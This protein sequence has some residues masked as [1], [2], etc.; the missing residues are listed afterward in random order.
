[1]KLLGIYFLIF[2]YS[3]GVVSFGRLVL[4]SG[5]FLED[6]A[7]ELRLGA[8]FFTG[9]SIFL[10]LWKTLTLFEFRALVALQLLSLVIFTLLFKDIFRKN[11][12][13]KFLSFSISI[14]VVLIFTNLETLRSLTPLTDTFFGDSGLIDPFASFGSVVHTFRAS[15]ISLFTIQ[16]DDIPTLGQHIGQSLLAA[17]PTFLGVKSLLANLNIWLISI[18]VFSFIF[19]LGLFKSLSFGKYQALLLSFLAFSAQSAFSL[20]AISTG[21]TG[22]S[23]L[24]MSSSDCLIGVFS[25]FTLFLMY[26]ELGKNKLMFFLIQGLFILSWSLTA[27]HL[28]LI[29]FGVLLLDFLLK[30][31]KFE[32]Y[33]TQYEWGAIFSFLLFAVVSAGYGGMLAPKGLHSNVKI[34]GLMQVSRSDRKAISFRNPG[35]SF[36]SSSTITRWKQSLSSDEMIST[37]DAKCTGDTRI[38]NFLTLDCRGLS[39]PAGVTFQSGTKEKIA[40]ALK[41]IPMNTYLSLRVIFWPLISLILFFFLRKKID[42]G[43]YKIGPTFIALFIGGSVITGTIALYGYVWELSRFFYTGWILGV[44]FLLLQTKFLK[45]QLRAVLITTFFIFSSL[46]PI[47]EWSL[48]IKNVFS[49]KPSSWTT[50][51]LQDKGSVLGIKKRYEYMLMKHDLYGSELQ[52][53]R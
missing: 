24:N 37:Y 36:Y 44:V 1:M 43:I 51:T 46:G 25:F 5:K 21:D 14:I 52:T 6:K 7:F 4:K 30:K 12:K 28:I 3:C 38:L 15:N 34:P 9:L 10:M 48:D 41:V 53:I 8:S 26:L 23:I 19:L 22:G 35:I 16:M 20:S 40:G 31:T 33:E 13:F 18:K 32:K 42:V 39:K 47:L 2:A 29:W 27:S 45:V 50:R 49:T 17:I 11:L